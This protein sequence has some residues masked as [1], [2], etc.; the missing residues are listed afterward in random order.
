MIFFVGYLFG[1]IMGI[2]IGTNP[3]VRRFVAQRMERRD[4]GNN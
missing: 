2:A 4:E 1:T 3:N